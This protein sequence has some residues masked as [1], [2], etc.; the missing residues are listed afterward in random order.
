MWLRGDG[1]TKVEWQGLLEEAAAVS[2]FRIVAAE[3][4]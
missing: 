1:I 4:A 2:D 3:A